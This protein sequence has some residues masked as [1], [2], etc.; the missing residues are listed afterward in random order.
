MSKAKTTEEVKAIPEQ[1]PTTSATLPV[2]RAV[3]TQ[4]TI[5]AE[6]KKE[7]T[8]FQYEA[9][10][11]KFQ[12]YKVTEDNITEAQGKLKLVRG[13]VKK[14]EDLK[15]ALKAPAW[16]ECKYWDSAYNDLA[17]PFETELATKQSD[18]NRIAGAIAAK[19]EQQ[20]QETARIDAIKEDMNNFIMQ[21]SQ[22]IASAKTDDEIVRIEKLLGSAKSNKIRWKQFLTMFTERCNELSGLIKSQK[23]T[24]RELDKLAKEQEAANKTGDDAKF[25]ELEAKKEELE[26][27]SENLKVEVQ[28]AAIN[29]AKQSEPTQTT[30]TVFPAV[31][32]RRTSWETELLTDQKSM[33]KAFEAGLLTCEI[34]K[35][36]VKTVIDTLKKSG[37]LKDKTEYIQDG[38][39]Y[40]EKQIF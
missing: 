35:E 27:R 26:V 21:Q 28:E 29:Q 19:Q 40:W 6:F 5:T 23:E 9:Q 14:I 37:I 24:I 33:K 12:A 31:A 36:K 4:D 30:P 15:G 20:R 10:L 17:K 8:K 16:R 25:I 1:T 2:V 39:R 13:F 22:A 18:V 32:A 38:I 7:L 11:E 3:P 34:N